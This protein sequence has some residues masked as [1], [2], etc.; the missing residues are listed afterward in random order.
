MLFL[1]LACAPS[2]DRIE[3]LEDRLE[4]VEDDL[5][6]LSEV[7][8][9]GFAPTDSDDTAPPEP[10]ELVIQ[11][12]FAGWHYWQADVVLS[13]EAWAEMYVT[14]GASDGVLASRGWTGECIRAAWDYE[15][16]AEAQLVVV[17][18][19]WP[20]GAYSCAQVV[21]RDAVPID[22]CEVVQSR[23]ASCD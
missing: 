18:V 3:D 6:E 15:G 19:D 2:D 12:S 21:G 13:E 22:G 8:D 5:A 11:L 20:N 4:A 14:A 1:L 16:D 10:G 9:T 7:E 23:P 17:E